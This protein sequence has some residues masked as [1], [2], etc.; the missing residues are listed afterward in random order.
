MSRFNNKVV[1]ISGASMGIGLACA[2]RFCSEGASIFLSAS[3]ADR[4]AKVQL[5]ANAAVDVA[6]HASNLKTLE[7]CKAAT[8]AA[9]NHFGRCDI[10]VNCAGATKGYY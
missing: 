4:L 5:V 8:D 10:L 2:Q 1:F 9:I 3:N 6:F 7:G